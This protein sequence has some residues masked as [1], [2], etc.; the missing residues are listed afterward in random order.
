MI[1]DYYTPIGTNHAIRKK[2]LFKYNR[3]Y[4]LNY[5]FGIERGLEKDFCIPKKTILM[6]YEEETS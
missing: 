4:P 5:S 1:Q 6:T 2:M 3:L